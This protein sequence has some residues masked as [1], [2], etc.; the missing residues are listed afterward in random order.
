MSHYYHVA[1]SLAAAFVCGNSTLEEI[2]E[3]GIK[4]MGENYHWL[5]GLC[6]RLLNHFEGGLSGSR[7]DELVNV[8][9]GDEGFRNA[10]REGN[11]P[12]I[13]FYFPR[14]PEMQ[15]PPRSLA[16]SGIKSFLT[17][18]RILSSINSPGPKNR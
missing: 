6:T 3:R 10:W 18:S 5:R 13:R 9:L 16:D 12:R 4:A 2:E 11:G 7:F 17:L 14:D 15:K 8:V 1:K